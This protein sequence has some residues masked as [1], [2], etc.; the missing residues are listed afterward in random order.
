MPLRFLV[1]EDEAL[2]AMDLGMLI[3]D[4][5]HGVVAEAACLREVQGLDDAIAPH[6]AF[7]DLQLAEGSSGLDVCAHIQS[8]W[9]DAII[10]FVTANPK[11]LPDDH[12][13]AHGVIAKPFSRNGLMSAMRYIVDGICNPPPSSPTPPDFTVFPAFTAVWKN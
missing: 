7:V 11:K 10:I 3:E 6:V 1:V 8:H 5:G 9:A 2:L 12:A 4:A 13:G